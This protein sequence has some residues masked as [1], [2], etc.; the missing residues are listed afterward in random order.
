MKKLSLFLAI[1]LLFAMLLPVVANATE[2]SSGYGN[3][4]VYDEAQ[5]ISDE[6]EV[7]IKNLN[8]NV[9]VNYANKPQLA[10][11][12]INDL[13]Y[14]MTQYKLDTF[15]DYGIGTA[16]EN[17]GMLFVFA[18]NDREY[19]LEIGDGFEKGS[20]LRK[21]LEMD[22]VTAEMKSYLKAE[23][24]DTAVK[25]IVQYLEQLMADEENGVYVQKEI[26]K[27]AAEAEAARLAE[28]ERAEQEK[29]K[30][31]REEKNQRNLQIMFIVSLAL[32]GIIGI[33]GFFK[34]LNNKREREMEI[35]RLLSQYSFQACL[36][37]DGLEQI[38][39]RLM[40]HFSDSHP[41]RIEENFVSVL[42]DWF[43]N[44]R[45]AELSNRNDLEYDY[46]AYVA[47]LKHRNRIGCFTNG[48]VVDV[49]TIIREVDEK[50]Q[51]EAELR[52][53]NTQKVNDFLN[54]NRHRVT[55]Q[56]IWVKVRNY[57][58][59]AFD[60]FTNEV[61][62]SQLEKFFVEQIDSLGFEKEFDKFLTENKDKIGRDFD[63]RTLYNEMCATNNY[64]NYHYG[65]RMDYVWMM[66]M[67]MN[68]QSRQK[69]N[70]IEQERRIQEETERRRREAQ[71]RAQQQSI[72]SR[73][74]SFGSSF[75]GGR[76]SG[77]GMRG[78]W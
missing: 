47:H 28:I 38:F 70:R 25:M 15:N 73:N 22:F 24:Y 9:F 12:I 30:A 78:G 42:H 13:P 29:L 45:I 23:D 7:Y 55:D 17:C 41:S 43:I 74:S 57:M 76:S 63:R 36:I 67:L 10:I 56:E 69:Q 68:H 71:R 18:I 48:S 60:N 64:R 21:D 59:N 44:D 61:R 20:L 32:A 46:D 66:Y 4:W 54:A 33:Y 1:L 39:D 58:H 72:S 5:V 8:E 11:M 65:M 35:K 50:K 6:T 2:T 26:E 14:N 37:D 77:G 53:I 75:G 31:E 16:N 40:K 49:D 62:D 27:A 34:W 52:K 19:G 3:E 51:R